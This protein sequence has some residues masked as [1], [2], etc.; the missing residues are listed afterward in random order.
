MKMRPREREDDGDFLKWIEEHKKQEPGER[1]NEDGLYFVSFSID[2]ICFDGMFHLL[3]MFWIPET[4]NRNAVAMYGRSSILINRE[5]YD[6]H[7]I[8]DYMITAVFHECVHAFCDWK[9]IQ[10]TEGKY[11]TEKF[12]KAAEDHGGR[13]EFVNGEVGYNF[14]EP[15]PETM[16]KIMSRL[17]KMG[18]L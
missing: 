2:K 5:I 15:T 6:E 16:K 9:M 17:R 7:G 18:V 1:I 11:H 13:G 10:D 14:V 4:M 3:P 8:D 12:L